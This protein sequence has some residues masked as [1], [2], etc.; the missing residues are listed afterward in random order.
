MI[1]AMG[2]LKGAADSVASPIANDTLNNNLKSSLPDDKLT[3]YRLKEGIER[4]FITDI[5]NPAGSTQAQSTLPTLSDWANY[6]SGGNSPF[7]HLPGG[8]NVLYL[9]G[10]V[11]FIKYPGMWPVSPLFAVTV[12][13]N[14]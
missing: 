14:S 13:E 8:S 11:S 3:I 2:N 1:T 6:K 7:N 9:D 5:N 10:H 12:G 4:F